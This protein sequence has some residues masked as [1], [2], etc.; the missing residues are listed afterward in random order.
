M[1]P[2]RGDQED[3]SFTNY[4]SMAESQ[5]QGSTTTD[6]LRMTSGLLTSSSPTD[7]SNPT[8]MY[9]GFSTSINDLFI[10]E[11]QERVDCCSVTCCGILQHDRDRFLLTGIPPPS[12]CKRIIM[13][14]AMPVTIFLA[15]GIGAM[16]IQDVLLNQIWSTGLIL[17]LVLYFCVQVSKGRIKRIDIRKDLLYTKYQLLHRRPNEDLAML[18]EHERPYEDDRD[19]EDDVHNSHGIRQ[20]YLGQTR[21]DMRN[22]HPCCFIGCYPEDRPLQRIKQLQ[23]SVPSESDDSSSTFP[24]DHHLCT[25]LYSTVCPGFLGMHPQLFGLCA[26]AQEARDLETIVLPANYR[27]IDYITMEPWRNYYPHIYRHR[28]Q[29][30]VTTIA[31]E[32]EA[33]DPNSSL[34]PGKYTVMGIPLS[35][36]SY[37][38]LQT[39]IGFWIVMLTWSFLGPIY[40]SKVVA[41]HGKK[42]TFEVIDWTVLILTFMQSFLILK[43][44]NYFL[45][46]HKNPE[47]SFDAIIK[48]YAAGFFL[49]ASL[50]LFWE[51]MAALVVRVVVSLLLSIAGVDVVTDPESD[52]KA[53][54]LPAIGNSY[55]LSPM[56]SSPLMD[57]SV[58]ANYIDARTGRPDY[59]KSFGYDHPVLYIMYLIIATFGVAGFIEEMCKYY[60]YRMVEHP[61]FLTKVELE[62]STAIIHHQHGELDEDELHDDEE[63]GNDRNNGNVRSMPIVDYANQLQSAQAMGAAISMAMVSVAIGFSCCENLMYIFIYAGK[64]VPLELGVLIQR[65]FFPVHPILAAIQSV[66]VCQRDVEKSKSTKVGRI[67]LSAV[68]FH[69]MFDFLIALIDFIGKLVG[70]QVEEGDLRISNITEL[71]TIV[72]CVVVMFS[73]LYFFYRRS[74]QQRDRLAEIDQQAAAGRSRFI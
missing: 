1:S 50:A 8:T 43:I 55:G 16:R 4:Q 59:A 52:L 47:L 49:S 48:Y 72:A 60:G 51:L 63:R 25:C 74:N 30:N 54:A 5:P 42:H 13:H 35:L 20:K 44:W 29:E 18:L 56:I 39:M 23:R 15:A 3:P 41:R 24:D 67:I 69:G 22:A 38:L 27:R 65:S 62:E 46:R 34:P 40:W 7:A 66:G 28:H 53:F 21:R 58:N 31:A 14:V 9:R 36:M 71:L 45:S 33:D 32:P 12:P 2:P 10:D 68:I 64:S 19:D 6:P 26:I 37:R 73:A 61:D 11:N 17:L 57:F 70:R